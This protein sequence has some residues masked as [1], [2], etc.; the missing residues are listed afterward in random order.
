MQVSV[1]VLQ[2]CHNSPKAADEHRVKASTQFFSDTGLMALL[3]RHD[4]VLWMVNM[5][6]PGDRQHYASALLWELLS[7][8]PK[9]MKVGCLYDIGCQLHHSCVKW[10]LLEEDLAR[11]HF[12]ISVFH[13]F[14]HNWTCQ[15]IYHPRKWEGFGLSDGH[16]LTSFVE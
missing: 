1:A 4:I 5:T 11:V 15:L 2:E 12:G 10:N 3:C 9:F 16:V 7:N 14:A 13:A 6:S 8:L